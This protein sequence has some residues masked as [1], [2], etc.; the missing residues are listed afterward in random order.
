MQCN[1]AKRKFIPLVRRITS[2]GN[3]WCIWGLCV[4]ATDIRTNGD[5][6]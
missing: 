4:R 3:R 5:G 1:Q 6:S 2:V